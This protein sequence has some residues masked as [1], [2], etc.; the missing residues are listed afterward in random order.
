MLSIAISI[1]LA[2]VLLLSNG[3]G[4]AQASTGST[5][6]PVE[7]PSPSNVYDHTD[8]IS[9]WYRYLDTP[10][11]REAEVYIASVF[12]SFGLNVTVQDYIAQRR[13]GP[14]RA[15]NVVGFL[16]GGCTH[17]CIAIGG[18]YD[19]N[20]KSSTGAYDNAVGVATVIELARTLSDRSEDLPISVIF[21]AWDSEE[22]GGAGSRHFLDNPIWDAEILAYINLDMFSLNW[23][24]RNQIP[25]ATEE[26]YKLNVYT[27]PLQDFT[28]YQN[29]EFNESVMAN[30]TF[31]REIL[32][33]I[34]YDQLEYPP[35]WVL[36]KDDD[37]GIS[38]HRFF[39][40]RG[41]PAVWFRGL[42]E[43]PREEGDF[44]EIA[45][46]HTPLDTLESM[47][48]YAGGKSELLKGMDAG[49]QLSH[50]LALQ[51]IEHYNITMRSNH[52][53][54]PSGDEGSSGSATAG[55]AY[56]LAILV[57]VSA[58]LAF[59]VLRRVTHRNRP[60]PGI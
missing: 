16:E 58:V 1:A 39:V 24:V 34:A 26:Y 19:N 36:V 53:G 56:G 44:N 30:F 3:G 54:G 15:A 21:G 22:G 25:M 2:I 37:A 13:D 10:G 8:T 35:E 60:E 14:V 55:G 57:A 59:F 38:D 50:E 40:E 31:F 12:E 51:L 33:T 43:R 48:R 20:E 5:L 52:D 47:E 9:Q 7:V 17:H 45:F 28:M 23:P 42:N 18:H 41:I 32:E 46:K 4:L 29:S 27:S 49:L 11:H 6:Q